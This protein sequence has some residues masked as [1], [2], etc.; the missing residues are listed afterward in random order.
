VLV[1]HRLFNHEDFR[2]GEMFALYELLRA[3]PDL[4]VEI[5]GTSTKV[6][7]TDLTMLRNHPNRCRTGS[8]D[9]WGRGLGW[10]ICF[11]HRARWK[12]QGLVQWAG[13]WMQGWR[14]W[15]EW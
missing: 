13:E 15:Q 7:I 4:A 11:R 14:V 3:R 1:L 8:G 2:E 6:I 12:A 10:E 9:G 5:L